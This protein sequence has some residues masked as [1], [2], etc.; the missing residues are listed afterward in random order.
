MNLTV[1]EVE[2][3]AQQSNL[4]LF[5]NEKLL[6]TGATGMIGS[7]LLESLLRV[8]QIQDC[9]FKEIKVLSL[10]GDFSSIKH[11]EVF[12]NIVFEVFDAR[13]QK[14]IDGFDYVV[15]A[16]SPSSP[17]YFLPQL[18][19]DKI[20]SEILDQIVSRETKRLLFLSSGEVYGV[21]K[22][23]PLKEE[24]LNDVVFDETRSSYPLSKLKAEEKCLDL[25]QKFSVKVQIARLFHTFGPG[26]RE[27][28]GRS[29]ADFLWS[30]ARGDRPTLKSSGSDVR[31]FLYTLD[32]VLG[33]IMLL[34]GKTNRSIINVGSSIPYSI[35][36]FANRI[37]SHAGLGKVHP[38]QIE[39]DLTKMPKIVVPDNNE[40]MKIGWKQNYDIDKSIESTLNW[41]RRYV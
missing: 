9:N 27:K 7:Y 3:I 21:S 16:A 22:A 20:N 13:N 24:D 14:L 4:S 1:N 2:T 5:R 38:P 17:K 18:E 41:I 12:K 37:S 28:D 40:L 26:L 30:A 25:E 39:L 32:A 15:H 10:R 6:I 34:T 33:F 36:D 11:L 29:F 31:T 19:M 35:H 23:K 8:C